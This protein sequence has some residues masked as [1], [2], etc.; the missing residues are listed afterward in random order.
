MNFPINLF[1]YMYVC[2][3]VCVGISSKFSILFYLTI[4]ALNVLFIIRLNINKN[5]MD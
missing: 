4:A 2:V 5:R 3:C 1:I